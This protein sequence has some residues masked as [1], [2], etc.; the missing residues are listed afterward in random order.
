MS[1]NVDCGWTMLIGWGS[2]G[3]WAIVNHRIVPHTFV[4][5]GECATV[6]AARIAALTAAHKAFGG[7]DLP[8][9]IA[10]ATG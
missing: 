5:G 8:A 6:Y 4:A 3:E 1:Q 9:L 10:E 7:F 2:P